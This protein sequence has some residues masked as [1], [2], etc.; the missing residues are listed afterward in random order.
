M[1]IRSFEIEDIAQIVDLFF[2]TVHTVNA[3]DYTAAQLQ[4][5]APDDEQEE[6]LA[7]WAESLSQHMT[8]VAIRDGELVGF[9]DMDAGGYL[10]RLYVHKDVQKQGVATALLS[11]LEQEARRLGLSEMRTDASITAV[12][13]FKRHGFCI[14]QAQTVQRRGVD[15]VNYKMSKRL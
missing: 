5:W 7:L 8:Y 10:D 14:L 13:F 9:S 4:A 15:L 12:P 6:K 2:D 11:K 1:H 3:K